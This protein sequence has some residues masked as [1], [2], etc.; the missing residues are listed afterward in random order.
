MKAKCQPQIMKKTCEARKLSRYHLKTQNKKNT[1]TVAISQ[2][3]RLLD[4]KNDWEF[5]FG[6]G[7][8]F[9]SDLFLLASPCYGPVRPADCLGHA[10]RN[11]VHAI[12]A[13]P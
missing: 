2:L 1:H 3:L 4:N 9:S 10:W 5:V 6:R 11:V 7:P 12:T 8:F 13:G